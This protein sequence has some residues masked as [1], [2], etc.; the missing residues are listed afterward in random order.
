MGK[1][2]ERR[3]LH[4]GLITFYK[5]RKIQF[6]EEHENRSKDRNINNPGTFIIYN[7]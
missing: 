4:L 6:S 2:L 7:H 5:F 3:S 1:W